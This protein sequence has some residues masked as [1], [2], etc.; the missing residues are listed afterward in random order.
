MLTVGNSVGRTK[1]YGQLVECTC[2]CGNTAIRVL[3]CLKN[4]V[5]RGTMPSC[6]QCFSDRQRLDLKE[7]IGQRFGLL[8]VIDAFREDHYGRPWVRVRCQC[9]CGRIVPDRSL[10]NIRQSMRL[11]SKISCR[12]CRSDNHTKL[13]EYSVWQH[14]KNRCHNPRAWEYPF[15]GGRGIS[16]YELWRADF[17]TFYRDIVAEIGKRPTDGKKWQLD[18]YPN[19]NGNYEPG[20]VRWATPKQN[21]NNTRKNILLEFRGATRSLNEISEMTGTPYH[22]IRGR[23]SKGWDIESAA[24]T[25]PLHP[26]TKRKRSP[27]D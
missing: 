20:N 23:L 21:C 9:E 13:P 25:P 11:G 19:N 2:D 8:L 27:T 5:K 15:Y 17:Y 14:I 24:T 6:D 16:V 12:M 18:R 4:S 7:L 22:T 26:G 1:D 10:S 3:S